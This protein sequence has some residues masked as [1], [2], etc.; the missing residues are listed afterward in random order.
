MT[1]RLIVV[2]GMGTHTEE[3][4]KKEVIDAFT[5][6]FGFYDSLKGKKIDSQFD[7]VAVS[8]NSFFDDYR[9]KLAD[10]SGSLAKRLAD[11]DGSVPFSTKAVQS[12][13]DV[14]ASLGEDTFFT[15]HWLDVLLYYLT[16]LCEPIRL[17][18]AATI[19]DSI[20]EIGSTNVHVLG[21]S[22]GTAVL[23]DTLAKAYGPENISSAGR[24]LNLSTVSHRLGGV[25]MVAN[26]S[27]ALQTF[28]A[29]GSSVVRPGPLGC[30][31]NF[32]EYR[33]R[34]DPIT[35]LR[36]FNPTDNDGWVPHSTFQSSYQLIE[37]TSVTAANVHGLDHYLLTP[38]VHL[39]L[40]RLLFGF[41]PTKAEQEAGEAAYI[42]TTVQGK[43]QALQAAF[44]DL[45]FGDDESLLA[46]LKAAKALKDMVVGFGEQF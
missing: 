8:Y 39:P 45:Q 40:F 1:K 37:P 14:E 4:V 33:H 10:H 6:A 25:H 29:A 42:Q 32:L 22:L 18:V 19:A 46:L 27:R 5:A 9:K 3:S 12:I 30:T 36:Q 41:R 44:G 16:L 31:T 38:K 20:G 23:H 11:I 24:S 2:H 13:N 34:L 43:A 21:H 35:K 26:V 7:V 15:T 17:K 28:V